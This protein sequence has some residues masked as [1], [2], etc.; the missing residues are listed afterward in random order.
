MHRTLI[1]AIAVCLV[2]VL[3]TDAGAAA[4]AARGKDVSHGFFKTVFGLEYGGHAD[5]RRVKRYV[6]PVR[7]HIS[8]RSG[9]KRLRAARRFV[10]ALPRRIRH[11]E[12]REVSRA[13]QANFRI[14]IVKRR[15]FAQVVARELQADAIA[16]N[17]RCLVG[18]TTQNGRIDHS[19]AV[20]V[21]DDDYL[22]RRCLVEEVLQGLGPMN[23]HASLK[24]SVFNDS[25]RLAA[26]T[27]F[28]EAILNVLY[29][30]TI[31]PG[32][33]MSEARRAVPRA[34]RE[35]GYAW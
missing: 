32:M 11:F 2:T 29:H 4:Q 12:G 6:S 35:L 3:S 17:A 15:D 9:H 20:I 27:N 16:M 1:V 21:G 34:M 7:F 30:P 8:D 23:D 25:S 10:A 13:D 18:V 24:N 33:S 26:F 22:F 5:A 28:D 19:V 31:R 14:L